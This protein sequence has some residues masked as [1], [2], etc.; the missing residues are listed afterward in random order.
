MRDVDTSPLAHVIHVAR[1]NWLLLVLTPLIA[2]AAGYGITQLQT[3]RYEATAILL[4]GQGGA[5][6]G[7]IDQVSSANQAAVALGTMVDDR[8]VIE[9]VARELGGAVDVDD[10]IASTSVTVPPDSQKIEVSVDDTDPARAAML[11]NAIADQFAQLVKQREATRFNL[12]ATVWQRAQQPTDPVAPNVPLVTIA[13]ALIGMLLGGALA[14]ARDTL[15]SAWRSEGDV[16]G[17]LGKP[18]L[19]VI[20]QIHA[21]RHR[22]SPSSNKLITNLAEHSPTAESYRML[23]TNV[24]FAAREEG[25]QTILVTSAGRGEGKSLT[26]ANLALSLAS[27]GQRVLLIDCDLRLPSLGTMFACGLGRRSL[28]DIVDSRGVV[29]TAAFSAELLPIATNLQLFRASEQP[30]DRPAEFLESTRM[31]RLLDSLR[32][33]FDAIVI[34]SPPAGHVTDA[35]I[36]ASKVDGVLFV[37]AHGQ[38]R[39]RFVRRSLREVQRA[40]SRVLG[41]VLN[42]FP[43]Q[44]RGVRAADGYLVGDT[45]GI[46]AIA[47]QA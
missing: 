4:A 35:T 8:V 37:L 19:A 11:A 46:P 20:P 22:T 36:L 17:D 28:A 24:L 34:D 13:A 23:R 15:D 18:V 21:R 1:R 43:M 26:A 45:Y 41:A 32:G 38:T 33:H 29:D 12:G 10:L 31:D 9:E 3:P 14:F 2:G 42:Q 16:E 6:V 27:V 47:P 30:V 40:D 39:R 5:T 25:L 7:N 44:R